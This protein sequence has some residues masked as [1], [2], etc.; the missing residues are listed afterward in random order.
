MPFIALRDV[1]FMKIDEK[2]AEWQGRSHELASQKSNQTLKD[3]PQPQVVVALGFSTRKR[4][5]SRPST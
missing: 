3:A 5:P 4:E 1:A 2:N